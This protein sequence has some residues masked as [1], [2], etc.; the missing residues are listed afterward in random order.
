MEI[1]IV[2]DEP[3]VE[4][5]F[6]QRFRREIRS[7]K[8]QFRFALSGEAALDYLQHDGT[9]EIVLI[10]S[11]IHMPGM[12]GLELLRILK[13]R[14]LH[15][16]VF[17]ITAYDDERNYRMALEY[18]A[19]DYLTKPIDFAALKQKIFEESLKAD[20]GVSDDS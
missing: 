14:F 6:R 9:T 15:L 8:I 12:N 3:D 4:L 17:M 7:G 18:G 2:D 1:M 16:T 10:L 20:R 11:D 19:D 13:E 5:L